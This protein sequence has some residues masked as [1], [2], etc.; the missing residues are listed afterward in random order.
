MDDEN[1]ETLKNIINPYI[2]LGEQ[3]SEDDIIKI[4]GHIKKVKFIEDL[5][6]EYNSWQFMDALCRNIS[7]EVF[8]PFERLSTFGELNFK[9]FIVLHGSCKVLV[10]EFKSS[11]D[12]SQKEM[13]DSLIRRLSLPTTSFL[14]FK[15]T[16]DRSLVFQLRELLGQNAKNYRRSTLRF[17]MDYMRKLGTISVMKEKEKLFPGNSYGEQYLLIEKPRDSTVETLEITI[18][19][20]IDKETFIRIKTEEVE[21]RTIERVGFLRK[22][23]IFSHLP[24]KNIMKIIQYFSVQHFIKNQ[25]VYR[26]KMPADYVYFIENGEFQ[27]SKTHDELVKKIIEGPSGFMSSQKSLIRIEKAR[28]IKY[29]QSLQ[30]AIRGRLEMLGYEEYLSKSVLRTHTCKCISSS[31]ILYAIKTTVIFT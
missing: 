14:N 17:D 26:D 31:G 29:S 27:L 1:L 16:K 23:P 7:I 21:R 11:K 12:M 10:P 24:K 6:N 28:E 19:A 25:L 9:F 8:A 4:K 18:C 3:R 20:V 13:K 22:L 15:L 2:K 5:T 30:V